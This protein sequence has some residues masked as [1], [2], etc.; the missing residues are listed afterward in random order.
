M[1]NIAKLKTILLGACLFMGAS[2]FAELKTVDS[3]DLQRY[4]GVWHQLATI[5]ASFQKECVRNTQAEYKLL[6][7]GLIQVLN[8]CETSDGQRKV[9]EGRARINPEFQT[10]GKLEVTF[11]K[12]VKWIWS[13]AGDYWVTYLDPNYE[14]VLVGAP[15]F[16]Y[17]W[18]LSRSESLSLETYRDLEER[19][20]HQGYDT[21][22]FMMSNT[23]A[24][25]DVGDTSLCDFVKR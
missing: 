5:P 7:D 9:A 22:N 10:S 15:D 6:E 21:C 25:P 11:V 23:P 4:Q 1:M 20:R 8:S 16:K 12:L 19:L 18:I 3:V 17:G 14:V 13:F 2:S 24:Q